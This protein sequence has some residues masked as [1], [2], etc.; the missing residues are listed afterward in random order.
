MPDPS[1]PRFLSD[2][3]CHDIVQRL[4]RL[5]RG[6]GEV[7]V[8]LVSRWLAN[9]RW[10]RNRITTSG[11]DRDNL[12]QVGRRIH[13]AWGKVNANDLS[14][15]GLTVAVQQAERLAQQWFE[16]PDADVM[17]VPGSRALPKPQPV[18]DP[19]LFY[20][21]TYHL[22]APQRAAA[23]RALIQ[24]ASAAGMLSAGYIEVSATSMAFL[25]SWGVARHYQWTWAHVSMTVRDPAG[26]GSGW[27]GVDW[28][29][30][31]KI[32]GAK[33]AATALDKCLNS[34]NVVA[35]EPGRYTTILEPQAVGDFIGLL[36]GDK[37]G[38]GFG[39]L[40]SR[41]GAEQI[42]PTGIFGKVRGEE[43]QAEREVD[44]IGVSRIGQKMIDERIS[45]VSDPMDP[46]L[47]VPPF[48]NAFRNEDNYDPA[49][50]HQATWIENGVLR[51][52]PY[53]RAYAVTLLGTSTGL[54]MQGSMRMQVSGPT[55]STEEMIATTVR[56]LY[57]TRFYNVTEKR[58]GAMGYTGLT[59]D[60]FWL[61]E[62]GK[63]TKPIKNMLFSESIMTALNN[64]EQLGVPV[65][66]FHPLPSDSLF[67]L[68]ANPQPLIVPPMKIRDFSFVALTDAI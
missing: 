48:H 45:I 2:A 56:G 60:G 5:A 14:D 18:A 19:H 63:I 1:R 40:G 50:Y 22:D 53:D 29:E 30:W 58:D 67:Y 49:V 33:L 64:V 20:D 62:N 37:W 32:D 23:A 42:G 35:V 51:N 6:G 36:T 66:V 55:T 11:E 28:P 7:Q 27:A 47:G 26:S 10:A 12:T 68:Y 17:S 15:T 9:V 31:A 3:D 21:S 61:I 13:G 25:T 59:R 16:I 38:W 4:T 8:A 41:M 24:S 44:P 39:G 57:V 34:R 52:L 43:P 46:E 54:P 65:R